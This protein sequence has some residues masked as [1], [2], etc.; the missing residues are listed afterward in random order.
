[1]LEEL[2]AGRYMQEY[3]FWLIRA[4]R[5]A[6]HPVLQRSGQN[7]RSGCAI[8]ASA[9]HM[10]E[11]GIILLYLAEKFDTSCRGIWQS[12][13]NVDWFVLVTA[14]RFSAGRCF[15]HFT[16]YAPVEVEHRFYHGVSAMGVLDKLKKQRSKFVAGDEYH[17][18]VSVWP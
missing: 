10:F 17:S 11:S 14:R 3:G 5:L 18:R 2:S 13:T 16:H 6:R 12:A 9:D 15:G 1:M 7:F 4:G 8:T